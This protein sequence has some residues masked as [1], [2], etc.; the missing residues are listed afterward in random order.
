MGGQRGA[1]RDEEREQRRGVHNTQ[2][3]GRCRQGAS[4]KRK[5]KSAA[6][7]A[8]VGGRARTRRRDAHG[9]R[10]GRESERSA[11]ARS[12]SGDGWSKEHVEQTGRWRDERRRGRRAD[13]EGRGEGARARREQGRGRSRG[14]ALEGAG[15][16]RGA[17]NARC[18][19]RVDRNEARNERKKSGKN[20]ACR[21]GDAE[22][23][24][25]DKG[26]A[27][28]RRACTRRSAKSVIAPSRT[29]LMRGAKSKCAN[30]VPRERSRI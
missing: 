23:G 17:L 19:S 9:R 25:Q 30:P 22:E 10:E 1:H 21:T 16:Q 3:R 27:H 15:R 13:R 8:A 11:S 18:S 14:E 24:G 2:E 28:K 26:G 20:G 4:V 12:V 7:G 5:E 29:S 6:S